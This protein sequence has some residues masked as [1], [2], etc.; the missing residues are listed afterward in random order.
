MA[1]LARM[2]VGSV[3]VSELSTQAA[4]WPRREQFLDCLKEA[5]AESF[6]I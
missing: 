1:A 5:P 6:H 2:S 4:A 3:G